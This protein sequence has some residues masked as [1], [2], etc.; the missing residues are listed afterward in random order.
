MHLKIVR[1]RHYRYLS[2]KNINFDT[3]IIEHKTKLNFHFVIINSF[4]G[5]LC[6]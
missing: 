6:K 1:Y 4:L 2:F 3:E 5:L